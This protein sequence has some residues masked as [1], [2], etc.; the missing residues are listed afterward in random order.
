[1]SSSKNKA[2]A[3]IKSATI[4]GGNERAQYQ[5]GQNEQD[6]LDKIYRFQL[7]G[8]EVPQGYLSPEQQYLQGG[9]MGRTLYDQTLSEAKDPNAYYQSTLQPQLQ[10]AEDFINRSYQ[11]RGLLNAGMPIES[12]GRAGVELAV[13][14]AEGMMAARSNALQRTA[15]LT[16]YMNQQ[17]QQNIANMQGQAN[18]RIATAQPQLARQAEGQA[19]IGQAALGDYY[20]AKSALYALPGQALGAAGTLA[21]AYAMGGLGGLTQ[22]TSSFNPNM[23]GMPTNQQAEASAALKRLYNAK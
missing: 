13:K 6:L 11:K 7:G 3:G 4:M 23:I 18:Q 21:G 15:G 20:G 16:E 14:E 8:G 10:L 5:A 22:S 17:G 1:M 19:Y 2:E 12:M 9:E